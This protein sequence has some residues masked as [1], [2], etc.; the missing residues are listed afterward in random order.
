M[1][2][3]NRALHV[4]P[5]ALGMTTSETPRPSFGKEF[6]KHFKDYV[7][8]VQ[9]MR[10]T[11]P[12]GKGT[13]PF[14]KRPPSDGGGDYGPRGRGPRTSLAGTGSDTRAPRAATHSARTKKTKRHIPFAFSK[15]SY[16]YVCEMCGGLGFHPNNNRESTRWKAGS[17]CKKLGE[18]NK[19]PMGLKYGME[20][21]I[22]FHERTF[23]GSQKYSSRFQSGSIPTNKDGS[24][25]T[26]IEGCS[27]GG[28]APVQR[29]GFIL[30]CFWYP[31]KQAD[32]HQLT[33]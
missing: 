1:E 9:A 3:V 2:D 24:P 30:H 5:L 6:A 25:E 4:L 32:R 31:R 19:G 11:L 26:S 8:Q 12:W 28:M 14:L 7:E 10:S 22:R 20:L 18:D 23:P 33:N 17:L 29:Q 15:A 13:N 21:P 27:D 16:K